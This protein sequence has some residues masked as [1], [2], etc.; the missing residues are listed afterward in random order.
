MTNK[1]YELH[2]LED[3]KLPIIYHLDNVKVLQS[4]LSNWH[5]NI[6][7]IYC[8]E[9]SGQIICNAV[10]YHVEKGDI[11][12]INSGALHGF[13]SREG[14]KYHCLIIDF[15]FLKSADINIDQIEFEGIICSET[16]RLLYE[17]VVKEIHSRQP[18]Q[19][20]GIRI[21]VLNLLLYL[22][23][24]HGTEVSLQRRNPLPADKNIK[25]AIAYLKSNYA[26]K[27]NLDEIAAIVGLSKYYFIR[28]FKKAT[29]MT[30][31]NFLN[32][33]RCRNA[34]KLLSQKKCTVKEAAE[35]CGFENASYFTKTFKKIMGYL[36]SE[37]AS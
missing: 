4:D 24:N 37:A 10:D 36:P 17:Q 8:I 20:A 31:L 16:A 11:F 19:I 22:A 32:I 21:S 6:E 5:E 9:G 15:D 35:M 28:E 34:N 18:Y 25:M 1:I 27:L 13:Y 14:F 2:N 3:R 30:V 23:R 12:V 29:G 7:I 26:Q 33:I